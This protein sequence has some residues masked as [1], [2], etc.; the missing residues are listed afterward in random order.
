MCAVIHWCVLHHIRPQTRR[1]R[2]TAQAYSCR[3]LPWC[4]LYSVDGWGL[5]CEREGG[6]RSC[7]PRLETVSKSVRCLAH[8]E[9]KCNDGSTVPPFFQAFCHYP[10]PSWLP[11]SQEMLLPYQVHLATPCWLASQAMKPQK[12][13]KDKEHYSHYDGWNIIVELLPY[14]FHSKPLSYK[15]GRVWDWLLWQP[16]LL[17]LVQTG[18]RL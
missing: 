1:D 15:I 10:P 18:L 7:R 13:L 9:R 6:E 4:V 8:M 5:R 11:S 14:Y 17:C 12:K 2:W 16:Y 3:T